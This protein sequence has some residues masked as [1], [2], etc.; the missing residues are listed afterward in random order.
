VE[1]GRAKNEQALKT[2]LEC[3]DKEDYKPYNV[4]GVQVVELGDLY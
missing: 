4:S 1:Y 3:K 2:L